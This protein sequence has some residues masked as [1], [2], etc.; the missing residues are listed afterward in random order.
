[1][2]IGNCPP[3]LTSSW[4][5]RAGKLKIIFFFLAFAA[6]FFVAP[7]MAQAATPVYYSVGQNTSDH[8]TGSPTVTIS[9]GVATFSVPQTA[10]NLGVGDKITYGT[11]GI[12]YISGKITT[13]KWN[14]VTAL[15][16]SV[17]ATTTAPVNSIAHAFVSLYAATGTG[18][19]SSADSSHLNTANLTTTGYVLNIPCYYDTG[20]DTTA[21]TISGW[22]T[23]TSTYIR[24]YTPTNTSTET[25]QSQ[26]H[27]GK[28]DTGKYRLESTAPLTISVSYVRADGL[29]V[30]TSSDGGY[31]TGIQTNG[32]VSDI[33][34]SD[35]IIF[36]N[37]SGTALGA[38]IKTAA[39]SLKAWNN[40]I[41]GTGATSDGTYLYGGTYYLYNNTIFGLG[42]GIRNANMGE[43]V[44]LKNNIS[45]N[46]TDN[47]NGTFDA[48]STN[49]L[50]GPTQTDAP[51]TN[52]RQGV[53]VKFVN[54]AKKD[55]HLASTDTGAR[56]FGANLS[57][58][59]NLSFGT[60]IDGQ[61]RPGAGP[62][63]PTWDIGADQ[64]EK[65]TKIVARP[66]T[67]ASAQTFGAAIPVYYSVGQNTS[68]HKTGS[69]T[70]TIAN[71]IATFSVP[72]TARNL[73]VGDLITYGTVGTAY[74]SAKITQTKWNVIT[75]TGTAVIATTTAPV[76]SIAHAFASLYAAVDGGS[77]GAADSSHLT[78]TNLTT[79]GYVLN[80]PCYYDTGPDTTAVNIVGWNTSAANYIRIYAPFNTSTE[81]NQSQRHNGKWNDTKYALSASGSIVLGQSV[82]FIRYDGLQ[83]K[84][85]ASTA[86]GQAVI[87][88]T[89]VNPSNETQI[90]NCILKQAGNNSYQ[91][92]GI[93]V[94]DTDLIIKIW[95]NVIYNFS[96]KAASGNC[97]IGENSVSSAYIYN[98]TLIGGYRNLGLVGTNNVIKNNILYGA[99]AAAPI[100]G[101]PN[102]ASDYNSTD[103]ASAAGG[104]HDRLSQTVK[105]VSVAKGDFHLQST[106][107]G[108]RGYGANLSADASLPF[109]TDVDGQLRPGAGPLQ[110]TWDIGADQT[111]KAT[112]IVARPNTPVTTNFAG[113]IPVY[114]SVGQNTSDH[115]T[116]SPTVT[117]ASGIA[118]FSVPQTARNMG[119]GDIITVPGNLYYISGKI[120]TSKWRVITSTGTTPADSGSIGV[121]SIAHVFSSL[122][123]AI[124]G[125]SPGAA[126]AGCLNTTFL[127][128][129]NFVL[130]IPCYYDT[131]PDTT[132][133]TISAWNTDATRYIRIYT[134][135]NTST[136]VNQSQR[137]SGKWDTGKWRMEVSNSSA[138]LISVG[139]VWVDGVQ[140]KITASSGNWIYGI[141]GQNDV[142]DG[143]LLKVSNNI[144]TGAFSGTSGAGS[145]SGIGV[146]NCPSGTRTLK[147]WN[148]AVYNF[149]NGTSDFRA[150]DVYT[151][152]ISYYYNNTSYNNYEG[153]LSNG[154]MNVTNNIVYGSGNVYAYIGAI[155]G[156]Y[157][158]TDGTD[159]TGQGS[160][161][162]TSQ[163]F[164]FVNASKGDFHLQSTDTGALNA[165]ADLR[166][167]A[168]LPVTTDIDGQ[169]RPA[170]N[171]FD[172]GADE[173]PASIKIIR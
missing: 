58:D 113:A 24:I 93:S 61:L 76:N 160:H 107:T 68:D 78:T 161:S 33:Q 59:S 19:G 54:A 56:G 92:N 91:E 88:I 135:T 84:K 125:G 136:E 49:N 142:P 15:G 133:V 37:T 50:S 64:T 35:N 172:I 145:A 69:P 159:V 156:D 101:T 140:V 73:G 30:K 144:I 137:H 115:K 34:I 52:A 154:T 119:V 21:I 96:N 147:V 151:G 77:Q 39:A 112:K 3:A 13:D 124:G 51:T 11:V 130:N 129:N 118:T 158:A 89:S 48:A 87:G 10:R 169:P 42:S 104:A 100:F 106:D 139:N 102:A 120:T 171:A 16:G 146:G 66:N 29:Q 85:T 65:S 81:V 141:S 122:S 105:F 55:F 79:T 40:I 90:S 126:G 99:G 45:Y 82:D 38:G 67:P 116:G 95:N 114:Y 71:G 148:N 111:E 4:Q 53:T 109:S 97:P 9:G 62:L 170:Q 149:K 127:A 166:N 98:N 25:N 1:M 31:P 128:S 165:G 80:I 132:A 47:Y 94:S 2:K 5:S 26:R 83:I 6:L 157:N 27:N 152:W 17:T 32:A 162:R 60:D 7:K 110:P 121:T 43:V 123:A 12:A 74:I 8:K 167:D 134:P 155:I 86:D 28:W 14:V 22:I 75:A 117:I 153:F 173:K 70:V 72:Q 108:A 46:N 168:N 44:Y 103:K 18:A 23:A 163:T 150:F 20:P 36:M 57:A 143:G 63:Q 41:Y 164:K 131:G 138:L